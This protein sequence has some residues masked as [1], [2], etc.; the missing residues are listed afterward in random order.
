MDTT[1]SGHVH[2]IASDSRLAHLR[3]GLHGEMI[4]PW[5]AAY[6]AARRVWNGAIDRYPALIVRC[7]DAEDV[8]R[9]VAFGRESHL[10]IAVR[11]GGHSFPGFSTCD[12]GL[13]IDL[14]PMK[15]VSVNAHERL[16]RAEPG[17]TLGGLIEATQVYGLGTNTGTASDTGIAGLTLGG[18]IGWLTGKCSSAHA[19]ALE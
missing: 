7:T 8:R 12:R 19:R 1:S 17:V 10:D 9:A 6:E 13:V 5:D 15:A 3:A 16:A 11:G 2:E 14:S 18:G 4:L